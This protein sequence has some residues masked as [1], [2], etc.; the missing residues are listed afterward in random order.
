MKTTIIKVLIFLVFI[1][2]TYLLLSKVRF[3]QDKSTAIVLKESPFGFIGK[4]NYKTKV[5]G[6][7]GIVG[8][9]SDDSTLSLDQR[10]NE[11]QYFFIKKKDS[12]ELVT[13]NLSL[14]KINDSVV[15]DNDKKQLA[16]YRNNSLYRTLKPKFVSITGR[17]HLL[18]KHH[19]L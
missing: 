13:T 7:Y 12:I 15:F 5:M 3:N 1:I 16:I 8:L 6:S 14:Y 18:G 11:S 9:T 4:V 2:C 10:G 17:H 19:K